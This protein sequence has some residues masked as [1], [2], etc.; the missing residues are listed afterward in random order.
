MHPSPQDTTHLLDRLSRGDNGALEALF[1][2]YKDSV[3][4]T[5]LR[6]VKIE[7]Y[8]EEILQD[9][10]L[11]LWMHRGEAP[12]IENLPGWLYTVARNRS[13][14]VLR[15][16]ARRNIHEGKVKAEAH[17]REQSG[18]TD[19]LLEE[20]ELKGMV[21][22][23]KSR[24]TAAQ[25]TAFYLMRELGLSRD[26]AAAQMGISPNTA[27]VHLLHATRAIR[28]HLIVKGVIVPSVLAAFPLFIYN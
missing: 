7:V 2:T 24:L 22:E 5:A 17:E 20:A 6:F 13:F 14:K 11:D 8:A 26:E 15:G 12:G 28:A 23:A 27:K 10:F 9:V 25:Q 1:L 19:Y 16:I 18:D 21:A 4:E 3:Y